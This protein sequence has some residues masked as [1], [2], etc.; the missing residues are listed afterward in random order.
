MFSGVWAKKP[1]PPAAEKNINA[2]GNRVNSHKV[3]ASFSY[4]FEHSGKKIFFGRGAS[5]PPPM[6][7]RLKVML[8]KCLLIDDVMVD[9]NKMFK[10]S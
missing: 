6:S 8:A 7:N 3:L 5:C 2:V 4:A 10:Y 9:R 1:P